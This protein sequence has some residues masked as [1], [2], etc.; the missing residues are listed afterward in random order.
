MND[1]LDREAL[2]TNPCTRSIRPGHKSKSPHRLTTSEIFRLLDAAKK[3]NSKHASTDSLRYFALFQ[4][5]LAT[6]LREGEVFA[7]EKTDYDCTTGYC[8]VRAT[9][10]KSGSHH[11]RSAPKTDESK[12][13]ILLDR[14]ELAPP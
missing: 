14:E 10:T 1:A 4:L 13:R 8:A 5:V 9:L 11:V 3:P 7:L 2:E 12:R 6:G